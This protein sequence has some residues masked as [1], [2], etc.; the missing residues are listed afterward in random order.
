MGFHQKGAHAHAVCKHS[1]LYDGTIE[2]CSKKPEGCIPQRVLVRTF[3]VK[4]GVE[5]QLDARTF[6]GKTTLESPYDLVGGR[7]AGDA[8]GSSVWLREG[9]AH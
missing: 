2:V 8:R 4:N 3:P 5:A 9:K 6:A 1:S 7:K